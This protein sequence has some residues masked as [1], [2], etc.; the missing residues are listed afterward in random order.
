MDVTSCT[1]DMQ[2]PTVTI[3]YSNSMAVRLSM[4]L[5]KNACWVPPEAS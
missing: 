1:A 5:G 3:D 2:V 4:L